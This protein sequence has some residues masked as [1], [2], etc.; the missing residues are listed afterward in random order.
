[1]A[2]LPKRKLGRTGLDVTVL[3]FGAMELRGS[4]QMQ[5]RSVVSGQAQ[6]ILNA[7]L[8]AGINFIDT[9]IDYGDSEE[10]IG[11]YIS[12]RRNEYFLASKC[13]CMV[14]QASVARGGPRHIYTRKNIDEGVNESLKRMKTDHLDLVQLHNAPARQ[15]LEQEGAIEALLDLKRHGKVRFIGSSS[16]LP[17]LTEHIRMGVFDAFQIPYSAIQREHEGVISQAAKAGAGT[18]IRGGVARGS[19]EEEGRGDPDAWKLWDSAKLNELLDGMTKMEFVLR[20]TITHPDLHTTIVGTL[21]PVHLAENVAVV[22]KGP[23]PASVYNEAK[24]RLAAAGAV[25]GTTR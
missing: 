18:I 17:N 13:G 16:T 22:R 5:G 8:D 9:S 24:R 21:N 15:T 25:P 12:H 19:P 11:K 2:D 1:M 14:D 10:S 6:S 3:G 23:L 7:V 4:S 20:F